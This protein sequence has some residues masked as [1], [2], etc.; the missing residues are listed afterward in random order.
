MVEE[1]FET[2]RQ[3]VLYSLGFAFRGWFGIEQETVPACSDH[4]I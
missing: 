1:K 4:G 2:A 3:A